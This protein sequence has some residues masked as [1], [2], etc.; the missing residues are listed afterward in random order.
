MLPFSSL[1]AKT[2][3]AVLLNGSRIWRAHLVGLGDPARDDRL[4]VGR[5]Q[6]RVPAWGVTSQP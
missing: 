5:G 2:I 1:T 6:V 4:D 3:L